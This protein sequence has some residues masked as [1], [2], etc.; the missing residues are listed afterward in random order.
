VQQ[1]RPAAN[2]Q[3]HAATD[4][5]VDLADLQLASP[6]KIVLLDSD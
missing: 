1:V 3:A 6:F 4:Q 2:Q 5:A